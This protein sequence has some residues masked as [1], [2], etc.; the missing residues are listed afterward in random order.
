VSKEIDFD[1]HLAWLEQQEWVL[2][3]EGVLTFIDKEKGPR[4]FV[5]TTPGEWSEME[6]GHEDP[7]DDFTEVEDP[8][9][10]ALLNAKK[11]EL[12]TH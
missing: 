6:V 2:G 10:V 12:R 1:K 9:L 4:E 5:E 3:D 7:E 8:G 11:A